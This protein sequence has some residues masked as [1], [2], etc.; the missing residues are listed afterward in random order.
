M[1]KTKKLF[2]T[3]K[4]WH[5]SEPDIPRS[6]ISETIETEILICGAGNAGMAAAIV[7]GNKGV[8]TI[9]IEKDKTMG[10]IKPYMGAVDTKAVRRIQC[11]RR[12]RRR[13]LKQRTSS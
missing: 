13:P 7:A 10:L 4:S 3:D 5:G 6:A 11:T 2:E 8:K 12:R 1:K 9:V